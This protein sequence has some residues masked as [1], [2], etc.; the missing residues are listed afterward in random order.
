LPRIETAV[1]KSQQHDIVQVFAQD[2]VRDILYVGGEID[3][4][5]A[6]M[7]SLT[8]AG[9]AGCEYLMTCGAEEPSNFCES[10]SAIPG[11]VNQNECCH[12][13]LVYQVSTQGRLRPCRGVGAGVASI[14]AIT[15][16]RV[17]SGSMTSSISS[18]E[19]IDV[20][21]PL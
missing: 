5:A 14:P 8:K 18:T 21:L 1:G 11:A 20:A 12:R 13:I 17:C 16:R 4:R 19:A 3:L 6:Q 10:V 15:Q 9:Q 2:M 7:R